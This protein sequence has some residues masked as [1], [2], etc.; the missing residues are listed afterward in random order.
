MHCDADDDAAD[1]KGKCRIN[2][3]KESLFHN[4]EETP[5]YF[6]ISLGATFTILFKKTYIWSRTHCSLK[7]IM[8]FWGSLAVIK[9]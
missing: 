6:F 8:H 9:R 1:T 5:C 4:T 3:A 2:N 7:R